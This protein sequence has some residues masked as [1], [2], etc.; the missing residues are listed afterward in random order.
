MKTG[1]IN[2][3]FQE[4]ILYVDQN[5]PLEIEQHWIYHST[6]FFRINIA[7]LC[8]KQKGISSTELFWELLSR[9]FI[10]FVPY[11]NKASEK[12]NVIF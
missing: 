5:K 3:N 2:S 9:N 10:S 7:G 1:T 12:K 6:R 11:K 8:W 4:G